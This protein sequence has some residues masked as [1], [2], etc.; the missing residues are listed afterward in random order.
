MRGRRDTFTLGLVWSDGGGK[1][2]VVEPTFRAADDSRGEKHSIGHAKC[3]LRLLV[4]SK[5]GEKH[6]ILY[7]RCIS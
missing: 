6:A 7:M 2:S 4:P 1:Q 3:R 5:G